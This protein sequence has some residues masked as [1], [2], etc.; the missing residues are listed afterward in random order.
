MSMGTN[1][2]RR[3]AKQAKDG[4]PYGEA[5]VSTGDPAVS[6]TGAK[7]DVKGRA[8][9]KAEQVREKAEQV[10]EKAE[11]V[12]E[13]VGEQAG[14]T[15]KSVKG[16]AAHAGE[17]VRD[18]V[19][20]LTGKAREAVTS[21]ETAPKTRRSGAGLAAFGTAVLAIWA[22]RRRARR[23]ARPWD[24]AARRAKSQLRTVRQGTR[25]KAKVTGAKAKAK[26]KA[27]RARTKGR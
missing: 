7:G 2:T 21:D 8:K 24:K 18:T 13:K 3:S 22:W 14:Q 12:R 16:K 9:E 15:A 11:Q 27:A 20:D 25:E 5:L 6:E 19:G 10:R 26:A 4:P 1:E 23:N 17:Q